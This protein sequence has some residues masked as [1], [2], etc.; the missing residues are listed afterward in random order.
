[1]V[2]MRKDVMMKERKSTN[3]ANKR[4]QASKTSNRFEDTIEDVDLTSTGPAKNP[5]V[6]IPF[7]GLKFFGIIFVVIYILTYRWLDAY[8]THYRQQ[9]HILIPSGAEALKTVTIILAFVLSV[10]LA[11]ST[12]PHEAWNLKRFSI[13]TYWDVWNGLYVT[14]DTPQSGQRIVFIEKHQFWVNLAILSAV[15]YLITSQLDPMLY[16]RLQITKTTTLPLSIWHI[17]GQLIVFIV[18]R[19]IRNNYDILTRIIAT[20]KYDFI[21]IIDSKRRSS[22]VLKDTTI[23]IQYPISNRNPLV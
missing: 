4:A 5:I 15:A 23:A 9:K 20:K 10:Y 12:R 19:I 7:P 13:K 11:K 22:Q 3:A 8:S 1:M 21:A 16:W 18:H 2:T 17:N 14:A 6:V